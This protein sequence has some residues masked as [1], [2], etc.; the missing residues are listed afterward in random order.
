MHLS[1]Q[2]KHQTGYLTDMYLIFLTRSKYLCKMRTINQSSVYTFKSYQDPYDH[3]QL[4]D[5]QSNGITTAQHS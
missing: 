4:T 1:I 3:K 5:T 2:A